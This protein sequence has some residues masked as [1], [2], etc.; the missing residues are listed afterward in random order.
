[1]AQIKCPHCGH[2]ISDKAPKCIYCG[3]NVIKMQK[4]EDCGFEYPEKGEACPA[5]GCP[6]KKKHTYSSEKERE[7]ENFLLS[8]RHKFPVSRFGEIRS[9]MMTLNDKQIDMLYKLDYKDTTIM[10]L[11][12]IFV[13]YLGVDRFL[14]GDIKNG[15]FKLCLFLCSFLIIPG[16]IALVWWIMDIF[17]IGNLTKEYNYNEMRKSAVIINE[18]W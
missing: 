12:S 10:L 2:S 4:C 17:K 8:E 5:C 14:L 13:G 16:I 15:L 6:S 3:A 9:W 7:V 18:G 11:V 1:M